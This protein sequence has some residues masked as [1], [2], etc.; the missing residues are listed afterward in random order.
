MRTLDSLETSGTNHLVKPR[1]ISEEC[2]HQLNRLK[3]Q[4]LK[5]MLIVVLNECGTSCLVLKVEYKLRVISNK[6]LSNS[7]APKSVK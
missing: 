5:I 7:L 4:K 3:S 2:R 6:M 1:H